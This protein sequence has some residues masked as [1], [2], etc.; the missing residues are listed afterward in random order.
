MWGEGIFLALAVTAARRTAVPCDPSMADRVFCR[1]S[2]VMRKHKTRLWGAKK[3]RCSRLTCVTW[4]LVLRSTIAAQRRTLPVCDGGRAT[5]GRNSLIAEKPHM[6]SH[7]SRS[8]I[9]G[10]QVCVPI[11]DRPEGQPVNVNVQPVKLVN[12]NQANHIG[13]AC[14]QEVSSRVSLSRSLLAKCL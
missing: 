1:A 12:V 8:Q 11:H 13:Q 3:R 7:A 10:A 4:N 5:H 6:T 2:R 14:G 9:V